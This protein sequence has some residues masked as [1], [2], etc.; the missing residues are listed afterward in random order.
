L[1][2]EGDKMGL[3]L[4]GK[5]DFWDYK[6][7]TFPVKRFDS[8]PEQDF[9]EI[10]IYLV[11]HRGLIFKELQGIKGYGIYSSEEDVPLWELGLQKTTLKV[12][13]FIYSQPMIQKSVKIFL[14]E[15]LIKMTSQ[16]IIGYG[17]D[18]MENGE[19]T[20]RY[21]ELINVRPDNLIRSKYTIYEQD[22]I[23]GTRITIVDSIS[24]AIVRETI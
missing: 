4:R 3:A 9:N 7:E 12:E 20:Q 17:E 22:K 21:E 14:E 19:Y 5:S 2:R 15:E 1:K 23:K 6:G 11:A 24:G 16:R 8:I 10:A 13:I 18:I